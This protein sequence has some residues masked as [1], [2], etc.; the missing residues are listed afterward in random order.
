V[1]QNTS[2]KL[3]L[4][5]KLEAILA[6][7]FLGWPVLWSQNNFP[8]N[9]SMRF[10]NHGRKVPT[11]WVKFLLWEGYKTKG[12]LHFGSGNNVVNLSLSLS[13]AKLIYITGC[14]RRVIL[15]Q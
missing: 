14:P 3:E 6:A 2:G 11:G 10:I 12:I 15:F 7:V 8:Y 4:Y 9:F 13:L 1:K 5:V